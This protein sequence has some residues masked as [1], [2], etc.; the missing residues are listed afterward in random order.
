M[1]RQVAQ[2]EAAAGG[3]RNRLRQ[4]RDAVDLGDEDVAVGTR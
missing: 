1:P 2:V 3:R 4:L